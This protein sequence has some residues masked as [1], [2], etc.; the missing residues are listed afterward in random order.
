M[1][2]VIVAIKFHHRV[3]N[4][5]QLSKQCVFWCR[6][7]GQIFFR[8]RLRRNPQRVRPKIA[9]GFDHVAG[10]FGERLIPVS[11]REVH[12]LQAVGAKPDTGQPR[13]DTFG[14]F[15][16]VEIAGRVI[17]TPRLTPGDDH[18]VGAVF[19]GPHEMQIINPPGAGHLG[20]FK[21]C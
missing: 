4:Q 18:A 1:D 21:F 10:G 7:V 20:H 9:N 6:F 14:P 12:H 11:S 17:A 5:A 2:D 16:G 13:A 19:E 3:L 8:I 15:G